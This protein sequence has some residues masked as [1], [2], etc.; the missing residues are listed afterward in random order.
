MSFA[1]RMAIVKENIEKAR[2]ADHFPHIIAVSKR[3]PDNKIQE[4]LDSGWRIFGENQVQEAYSRWFERKRMLPDLSLHLIGPLQSNKVKQ[5]IQL[6]DVIHTIDRE[7]IAVKLKREMEDSGRDV[8][9]FIQVNIGN[10]TSKSGIKPDTSKAF[11]DFCRN[12]VGLNIVGLMCIPPAH[13]NPQVYFKT[14]QTLI[15]DC[16]L[17]QLSMGMSDDYI[18]AVRYESTHVRIGSSLFGTR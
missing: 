6:F 5:A 16:G 11:V 17:K 14:M 1:S 8:P 15:Y 4:A 12:D 9:C 13:V 18:E 3:Q 7:K 2:S 10:E